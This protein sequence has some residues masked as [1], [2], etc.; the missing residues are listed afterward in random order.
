MLF[1]FEN[2]LP[3]SFLA[4]LFTTFSSFFKST[5]TVLNLSASTLSISAFRLN[6]ILLLI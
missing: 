1:T 2:N 4:P 3:D 5:G 6:Q